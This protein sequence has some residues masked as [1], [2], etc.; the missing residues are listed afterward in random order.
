VVALVFDGWPGA[1]LSRPGAGRVVTIVLTA[2]VAVVLNRA[3]AGYADHVHWV[4]ATADDWV[5]VAGLAFSA[6]GIILHVAIGQ[7]WPLSPTIADQDRQQQ[8]TRAR[9][10]R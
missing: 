4:R 9:A 3:L 7:R 6:V 2:A 1:L 8:S 10:T 5:T